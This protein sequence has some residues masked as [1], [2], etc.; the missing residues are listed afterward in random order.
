MTGDHAEA[1]AV[2]SVL[3]L[4]G[5]LGVVVH[6]LLKADCNDQGA[7]IESECLHDQFYLPKVAMYCFQNNAAVR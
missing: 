5:S 1:I 6:T 4:G 7:D 2:R 3:D